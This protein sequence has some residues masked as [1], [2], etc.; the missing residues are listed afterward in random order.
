MFG[1]RDDLQTKSQQMQPEEPCFGGFGNRFSYERCQRSGAAHRSTLTRVLFIA[2]ISMLLLSFGLLCGTVL[3][4][5]VVANSTLYFPNGSNVHAEKAV[6]GVTESALKEAECY[7]KGSSTLISVTSEDSQ[8]YRIPTGVM[9]KSV[10]SGEDGIFGLRTGDIIVSVNGREVP[11]VES[12]N[13]AITDSYESDL[14]KLTVF[15]DNDYI[16]VTMGIDL[17]NVGVCAE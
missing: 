17:C 5:V 10:E 8:R 11:D 1:N 7:V 4:R 3:F 16:T 6:P 14:T 12:L 2:G 15:R 9:I 13:S